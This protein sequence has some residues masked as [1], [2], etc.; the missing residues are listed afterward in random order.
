[1]EFTPAVDAVDTLEETKNL[2]HG[3]NLFSK[4]AIEFERTESNLKRS[5]TLEKVL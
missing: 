1:M 2:E 3:L 4:A 5:S